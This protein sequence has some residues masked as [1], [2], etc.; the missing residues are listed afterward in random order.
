[1]TRFR[2]ICGWLTDGAHLSGTLLFVIHLHI[3]LYSRLWGCSWEVC[4]KTTN[5]RLFSQFWSRHEAPK[6]R[7]QQ[8]VGAH[9]RSTVKGGHGVETT[10][11]KIKKANWSVGISVRI[12]KITLL[13]LFNFCLLSFSVSPLEKKRC[14]CVFCGLPCFMYLYYYHRSTRVRG[15]SWQ[16]INL[17]IV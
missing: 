6:K 15:C 7:G 3:I 13:C 9:Q 8:N 1:M 11:P 12:E 17:I 14:V 4:C 16:L 2:P 10:G 5:E